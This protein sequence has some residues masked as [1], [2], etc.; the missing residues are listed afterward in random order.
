MGHAAPHEAE[1]LRDLRTVLQRILAHIAPEPELRRH[2]GSEDGF[3]QTSWRRLATEIGVPGLAIP[4]EYGGAGGGLRELVV[5]AEELGRTLCPGPFLSTVLLSATLVASSADREAQALILPRIADG[6]LVASVSVPAHGSGWDA[7]STTVRAVPDGDRWRVTGAVPHV[8]DGRAAGV[9]LVPARH[10]DLV[11][12]FL[13]T[14]EAP[15]IS[16][17]PLLAMDQTRRFARIELASAP[18]TLIGRPGTASELVA[19]AAAVAAVGLAADQIGGT[20]RMLDIT[21][22]YA[23][24]RHQFGRP[25]GSFQA[26]KHRLADMLIDT[27]LARAALEDAVRAVA[28]DA[29]DMDVAV[30]A[31]Q[32]VC[33][34]TYYDVAAAAIQLHGGIGFTWEHSAHLYFKRA[35]SDRIL[36]G[37]P[38]HHIERLTSAL[39]L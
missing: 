36:L 7:S 14:P 28:E 31:A 17:E 2:L 25:I 5:A 11:S 19:R 37:T 18:A 26:V 34:E 20:A 33:S 13:V 10:D 9:L 22:E 12:V 24:T 3:D 32:V 39:H 30:S 35:T 27:E 16:V 6:T 21:T 4:E 8:L 23:R 15:S 29:P 38:A 1:E